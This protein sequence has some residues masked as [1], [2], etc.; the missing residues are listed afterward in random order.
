MKVRKLLA[1]LLAILMFAL[2]AIACATQDEPD[3]RPTTE[4]PPT[5]SQEESSTTPTGNYLDNMTAPGEFPIVIDPVTLRIWISPPSWI[6]DLNENWFTEYFSNKT[7][8]NFEF[9]R[10]NMEDHWESMNLILASQADL[11][12]VFLSWGISNAQQIVFGEQ[13]VFIPLNDM[14]EEYGLFTKQVFEYSDVIRKSAT[15]PNGVIYGLPAVNECFH[16]TMPFK[17]W[18]DKTMLDALGLDLPR[19]TDDFHNML[20]AIKEMDPFN[21]PLTSGGWASDID[22]FLMN[23]FI[24][25]SGGARWYID[26]GVIRANAIEPEW[27][28]G[29]RY[30]NMLYSEGLIDPEF[31]I[32]DSETLKLFTGDSEG[33]RIGVVT[34]GA[35][36][37]VDSSLDVKDN[38]VA[39]PPLTGPRGVNYAAEFP[40]NL[41]SGNF[42]ITKAC[43]IPEIAFRLG[44]AIYQLFIEEDFNLFGPQG[45][46]WD[47]AEPGQLG[48][49]GRAAK[50]QIF[51]SGGEPN[52]FTWSDGINSFMTAA[53]RNGM[54]VDFDS[55]DTYHEK[56][57]YEETLNKYKG[58]G[59][60]EIMPNLFYTEEAQEKVTDWGDPVNRY[61]SES[62]VAFITGARDINNDSE[63]DAYVQ[64]LINM[65][66]LEM[67]DLVQSVYDRLS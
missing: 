3:E 10:N 34:A 19:T 58:H 67:R 36:Q 8:I 53:F 30:M 16:C 22:M 23:A 14:I 42:V 39:L 21:I 4:S 48:V 9:M 37:F 55:W 61:I 32:Q 50:Y 66:Y 46:V 49:D 6:G 52:N 17:A 43:E 54:A 25:N 41:G 11:P 1:L 18:V 56:I 5:T 15:A 63:W 65:G 35:I 47:Y 38:F 33:N 45:T 57:L 13:G 27:R 64:E 62:L 20:R 31:M 2:V 29:L 7:N 28:E 51:M 40:L 24:Y 44:D 59:P 60:A 12:D 26:N